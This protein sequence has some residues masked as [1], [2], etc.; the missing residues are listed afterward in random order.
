MVETR[1]FSQRHWSV[2][3][4]MDAQ[5]KAASEQTDHPL[6]TYQW[7]HIDGWIR[8]VRCAVDRKSV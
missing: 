4:M 5:L 1:L 2:E 7:R 3:D 8:S 6:Q